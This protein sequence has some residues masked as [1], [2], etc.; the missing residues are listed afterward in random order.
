MSS[1]SAARQIRGI[2]HLVTPGSLGPVKGMIGARAQLFQARF[3]TRLHEPETQRDVDRM[4]V[5]FDRPEPVAEF[6]DSLVSLEASVAGQE[7]CEFLSADAPDDAWGGKLLEQ[8]RTQPAQDLVARLMTIAVV[9]LLEQV[10]IGR[11]KRTDP[12]LG[13]VFCQ[14]ILYRMME[15]PVI[16]QA[17]QTVDFGQFSVAATIGTKA[18]QQADEK[19]T[20]QYKHRG[21]EKTR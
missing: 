13:T 15:S 19:Q 11:H 8:Q 20:N 10:H 12:A 6:T 9:D 7:D 5:E 4:T 18:Q 14:R 3:A 2:D 17:S 1:D 21:A 16:E